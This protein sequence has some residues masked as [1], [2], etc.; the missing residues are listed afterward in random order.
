M[1]QKSWQTSSLIRVVHVRIYQSGKLP[2]RQTMIA[3]MNG[4]KLRVVQ[5]FRMV[6]RIGRI[7]RAEIP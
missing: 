5:H 4:Q 6:G 1:G 7:G 3:K 2:R